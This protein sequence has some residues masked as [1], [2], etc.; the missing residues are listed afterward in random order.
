MAQEVIRI[1]P[2]EKR[3]ALRDHPDAVYPF[4]LRPRDTASL[5][6][7]L[8]DR[9]DDPARTMLP[10]IGGVALPL[11]AATALT[12]EGDH[13]LRQIRYLHRDLAPLLLRVMSGLDWSLRTLPLPAIA[14]LG[15]APPPRF[16]AD[17]HHPEAP[18][19]AALAASADAGLI[20]VMAIGNAGSGP[21]D[22][23]GLVNPLS[24]SAFAISVGACDSAAGT[25]APFSSR[26]HPDR[27]ETGP[28]FVAQGVGVVAP[29]PQDGAKSPERRARDEG[30]AQFMSTVP[31]ADRDLYTVESGSS[32]AAAEVSGAAGQVLHFLRETIARTGSRLGAPPL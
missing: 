1:G 6:D 15:I 25:I 32:Q 13:R 7:I 9:A 20:P 28:D 5:A 11:K 21:G 22:R 3:A 19:F 24:L 8:P 17:P 10:I 12:P 31:A 27:P 23:R 4:I 2:P 14:S 29:F 16:W 30:N 26:G 18:A